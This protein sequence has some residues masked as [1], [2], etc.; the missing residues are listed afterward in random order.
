V[1][2]R[3][4]V[5]QAAGL[6]TLAASVL[7]LVLA[8]GGP[9]AAAAAMVGDAEVTTAAAR[10]ARFA[11]GAERCGDAVISEWRDAEGRVV[12]HEQ[13]DLQGE[14]WVRY[15]LRRN[16]V[17][18]D[19]Q[20][21]RDGNLV[22]VQ[23]RNGNRERSVSLPAQPELIAGPLLVPFLHSRLVE[24]RRGRPVDFAYLVADRGLRLQLRASLQPGNGIG[25]AG[26]VGIAERF[27]HTTVRLEAASLLM[28]PFVP[29]TVLGFD[30]T[31][32]FVAM[33]GRL[34]P[35]LGPV[36][37]PQSLDGVMRVHDVPMQLSC[38]IR[39]LP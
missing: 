1:S 20:A 34:L 27:A 2:A 18:Q 3:P 35:Q 19:V 17:R 33:Q 39:K 5:S 13:L 36:G 10:G 12:A 31:G 25:G 14:V 16:S 28:R 7:P 21:V 4:T 26:T 23:I 11:V 6:S 30:A 22:R 38:H 32:R 8:F 24:L 37:E 9:R 29:P 15:R